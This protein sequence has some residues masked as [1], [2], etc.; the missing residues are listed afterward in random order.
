M[1]HRSL[2]KKHNKVSI[3]QSWRSKS[4]S[5]FDTLTEPSQNSVSSSHH[6]RRQS[7]R[8]LRTARHGKFWGAQNADV[9]QIS[10]S[11]ISPTKTN[12]DT[13]NDVFFKMSLRY[14]GYPVSMLVFAGCTD[15]SQFNSHEVHMKEK[16]PFLAWCW[17]VVVVEVVQ[18]PDQTTWN[19][20]KGGGKKCSMYR[21]CQLS[22]EVCCPNKIG[23]STRDITN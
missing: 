5:H 16:S 19:Q 6:G 9:S 21:V 22:L 2:I 1:L 11:F 10:K 18:H 4:N 15:I 3:L 13:K 20:V 12:I 17:C 8:S 14:F 23:V 7:P